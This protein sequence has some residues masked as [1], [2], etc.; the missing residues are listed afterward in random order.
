MR[1]RTHTQRDPSLLLCTVQQYS[2]TAAEK[3]DFFRGHL[4]TAANKTEREV[5]ERHTLNI[6]E[7]C[8][9]ERLKPTM[10]QLSLPVKAK[11]LQYILACNRQ[12]SMTCACRQQLLQRYMKSAM[13]VCFVF[14]DHASLIQANFASRRWY[15]TPAMLHLSA[16]PSRSPNCLATSVY[17]GGRGESTGCVHWPLSPA[18]ESASSSSESTFRRAAIA[19]P[20]MLVSRSS[21]STCCSNVGR[22]RVSALR[23]FLAA[24]L[25]TRYKLSSAPAC[26]SFPVSGL[27]GGRRFEDAAPA[28]GSALDSLRLFELTHPWQTRCISLFPSGSGKPAQSMKVASADTAFVDRKQWRA[29]RVVRDRRAE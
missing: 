23:A 10:V 1:Y 13:Q 29:R 11:H 9:R 27:S 26:F 16:I 24:V 4:N 25:R 3:I 28:A 8:M 12:T 7:A 2:T 17:G 15:D 6:S 20:L 18:E 14:F 22:L 21:A 19:V 5:R